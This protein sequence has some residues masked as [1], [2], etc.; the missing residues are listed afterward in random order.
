MHHSEKMEFHLSLRGRYSLFF[1]RYHIISIHEIQD[2]FY[3]FSLILAYTPI[4]PHSRRDWQMFDSFYYGYAGFFKK[5]DNFSEN[6]DFFT[7]A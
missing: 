1:E 3:I 2:V 7:L 4:N 5:Q 6:M